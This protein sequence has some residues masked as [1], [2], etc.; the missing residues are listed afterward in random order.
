MQHAYNTFYVKLFTRLTKQLIH[1]H[2]FDFQPLGAVIISCNSAPC[3]SYCRSGLSWCTI[4][5]DV[6]RRIPYEPIYVTTAPSST[7]AEAAK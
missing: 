6:A 2:S 1:R 4:A 7:T 5:W 3:G